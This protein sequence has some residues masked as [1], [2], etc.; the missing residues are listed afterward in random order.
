M[1]TIFSNPRPFEGPFNIIQRNAIRSWLKTCPKCEIILFNDEE[2]T[3][4]KIAKE[5]GVKCVTDV[6]CDEFGTPLLSDVFNKVRKLASYDIVAQV[7]TDIILMDDFLEAIWNVK[8]VMGEKPFFMSGRRWNLEINEAINFGKKNWE[9]KLR[10]KIKKEGK[11]HGLSGMDYWVLPNNFLFE[12]PPFVIGRPG[13]DSWLV[14]KARSLKMPVIDATEM[15]NIIHQNHNYP[16]KKSSFFEIEKQRNL[17]LAGG[18]SNMCTLRDADW[19]LTSG[20]LKR[21]PYPR[22]I[23]SALTLFYPWRL[24][25]VFKRR[26]QKFLNEKEK[27]D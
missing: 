9:S 5:F 4:V 2:G 12:I 8:M 18:F 7:N 24:L 11:L 27:L 20:G 10:D 16:R 6:K 1:V 22:R 3:S 15:V 21:P 19:I 14:Y 25:L 26:L 23:F 13:M 17:K